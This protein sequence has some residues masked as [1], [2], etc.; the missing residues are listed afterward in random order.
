[1]TVQ[2]EV[3]VTKSVSVE[4]PLA[5]AFSVFVE[6]RWWPVTT[7]HIAPTP[8]V[9]AVLEPFVGGR[10]YER[11]AAGIETDWGVVQVWQPP[12]RLVVTWQVNPQWTYE[13]DPMQGSEIEV[14]FTPES[15]ER[16]RVDLVHRRLERYG[17]STEYMVSILDAKG[18]EPLEAYARYV[19]ELGDRTA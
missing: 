11:D 18:G 5:V 13:A 14:T 8:G 6:Q 1:M 9:A 15:A 16:T 19:S 7:H 2:E 17:D 10:W 12:Y 4:A 3:I